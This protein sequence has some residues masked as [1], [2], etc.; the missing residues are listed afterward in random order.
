MRER[1]SR[2]KAENSRQSYTSKI[3]FKN[4]LMI[5]L[6]YEGKSVHKTVLHGYEV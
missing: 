5:L 3:V 2:Y 6:D 4:E 1:V